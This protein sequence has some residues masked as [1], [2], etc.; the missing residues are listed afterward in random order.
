MRR[1]L[2][3]R[4]VELYDN[5]GDVQKQIVKLLVLE[6]KADSAEAKAALE[7]RVAI[8]TERLDELMERL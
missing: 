4:R 7:K 5:I 1:N 6:R 3:L 2:R 8:L